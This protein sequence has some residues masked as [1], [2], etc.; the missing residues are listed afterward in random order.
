MV[1]D[2]RKV[3][4]SIEGME[5]LIKGETL[6]NWYFT[7]AGM[8]DDMGQNYKLVGTVEL[9]LPSAAD[10]IQQ[11]LAKLKSKEDEIQAEAFAEVQ[12]VQQRRNDLLTIGFSQPTEVQR[13]TD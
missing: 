6:Y 8:D 11:V 7:T 4:L 10:C 1:K 3:Y 9:D 13:E 5:R 2:T 12:K